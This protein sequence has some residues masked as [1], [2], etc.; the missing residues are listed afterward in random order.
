MVSQN[1]GLQK[2]SKHSGICMKM[3]PT[4]FEELPSQ[5]GLPHT[6][7]FKYVQVSHFII[8][9]KEGNLSPLEELPLEKRM[10]DRLGSKGFISYT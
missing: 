1:Y 8:S 4:D 6:H 10:C 2:V 9:E 3:K 7:F 5:Y